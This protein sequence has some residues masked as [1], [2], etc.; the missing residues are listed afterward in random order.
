AGTA[1]SRSAAAV[2]ERAAGSACF[3]S[4]AVAG[5]AAGTAYSRSAAVAGRAA[6]SACSGSAAVA[7]RA[8][9]S[10]YSRSA[11]V[12]ERAA[13]SAVAFALTD[14]AAEH[15]AGDGLAFRPAARAVR[16]QAQRFQEA[17]TRWP[18]W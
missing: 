14:V 3:R 7:E 6:V 12:A 4:S 2:A 17:Q 11:A 16:K 9:V 15:A 13:V 1:Y 18:Y 8:A 10:A 5:R